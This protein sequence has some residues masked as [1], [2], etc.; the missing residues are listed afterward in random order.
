MENENVILFPKWKKTLEEESLLALK[1]KRY[2][3]AL[4]KLDQLLDYQ[5]NNHEIVIGKLICL[6][7]LDRYEDAQVLSEELLK[8]RNENYYHY[9]HIY[10]TILFQTNQYKKLMEQVD[11]EL[12]NVSVPQQMKE[13]FQQLYDMS[14]KMNVEIKE[15]KHTEYISELLEAVNEQN[16]V[17][18]W[19]S[20]EKLRKINTIPSIKATEALLTESFVH[21]VIKTAIFK[22]LQDSECNENIRIHKLEMQVEVKP[23]QVSDIHS[24]ATFKQILLLINKIELKNPT[25]YQLMETLLYRYIYVRYPIMPSSEHVKHIAIALTNIGEAYLGME[26]L[27]DNELDP[28]IL[29]YQDEIKLCETLY[30]SIIEE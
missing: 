1:E 3:E 23:N 19:R 4:H 11:Y 13:Q 18:Q 28:D 29:R 8:H 5:V 7:E 16:H 17:K 25:L 10:L 20:V 24:H 6:M 14:E 30:L 22:W 9:V 27:P 26:H 15:E 12:D 2:E 21:P